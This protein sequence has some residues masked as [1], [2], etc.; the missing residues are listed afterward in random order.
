MDT[1]EQSTEICLHRNRAWRRKLFFIYRT[2]ELKYP[3]VR[4]KSEKKWKYLWSRKSKLIRAQQLGMEYPR[5]SAAKRLLQAQY[6]FRTYT[7]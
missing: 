7:D 3:P 1:L 6:D 5:I 2:R 4:W